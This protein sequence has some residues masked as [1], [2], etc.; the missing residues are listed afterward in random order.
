MNLNTPPSSEPIL[1]KRK[2]AFGLSYGIVAGLAFS[3]ALWGLDGLRLSQA[4]AYYPW[5]KFFA[6]MPLAVLICGLVGWLTARLE[7]P[8]IGILLW[9]VAAGTLAWLTVIVPIVFS[10]A[11]MKALN[12]DLANLLQYTI[13]DNSTEIA[14]VAFVWIAIASFIIAVIQVPMVEQAAFSTSIFG[15][16]APHIIC[17]FLMLVSGS[18]ADNL[19]N[20]FLR[21]PLLS[22]NDTIQFALDHQGKIVDSKAAR[23]AHIASLRPVQDSLQAKRRLVVS[24]F[25][26][27]LEHVFILINFNGGWVECG[28]IFNTP[29]NCAPVSP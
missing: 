23:D 4:F 3:F 1:R 25:D 7:R 14:A 28:T 19:N 11:I 20:Q 17:A 27:L 18:V 9:V 10:P 22:M 21:D 2:Q 29:L 15:K 6:G 24:R 13:Y 5:T 8:L 26:P 16:I 12:P